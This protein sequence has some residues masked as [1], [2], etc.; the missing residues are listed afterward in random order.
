MF[1][2]QDKD[3]VF[4]EN[5]QF[6]KRQH[7]TK[8][9]CIPLARDLG[10]VAP[11]YFKVCQFIIRLWFLYCFVLMLTDLLAFSFS[12]FNRK[13]LLKPSRSGNKIKKLSTQRERI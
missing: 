4:L 8:I 2:A 7:H 11:M 6:L 10:E 1:A 13:P 12:C 3:V 5:V 9:D